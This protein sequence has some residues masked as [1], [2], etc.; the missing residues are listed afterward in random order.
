MLKVGVLV[1]GRGS[2][3]EALLRWQRSGDLE[4]EVA[5]VLSNRPNAPALGIAA[6]Y[7]VPTLVR[8]QRRGE[9]RKGAQMD[10]SRAMDERG[11]GL[12]VHAGFDRILCAAYVR[13]WAGRAINVHPSLL[14]AFA[15]S[16]RA[17]EDALRRGVRISGCT[18][19]FV[20]EEVDG[21]P[22]I[23]QAAVPV[24]PDDDGAALNARILEQEHRLLPEAVRA[25]AR[26]EL[27]LD[28][29]RV[30]VGRVPIG[31]GGV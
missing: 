1:S 16:L 8:E 21:G 20:T 15:G 18:V 6:S 5:L 7:G 30:I 27:R 12:A 26:G 4:A 9:D 25:F 2:N 23:S 11:V 3:L 24:F 10:M 28:G 13:A 17:Q 29:D 31:K 19:H 14:P 22:I